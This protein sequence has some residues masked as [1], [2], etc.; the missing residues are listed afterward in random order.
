PDPVDK[1]SFS[2]VLDQTVQSSHKVAKTEAIN[3]PPMTG[4]API[5][6]GNQAVR[7]TEGMLDSLAQYQVKLADASVGLREVAPFVKHMQVQMKTLT[8]LVN[9]MADGDPIKGIATNALV[10]AAKEVARFNAG[11][12]NP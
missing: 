9:R 11:R 7:S 12:Y 1:P 3:I 4:P 5:E 8:P 2:D 6:A 10:L